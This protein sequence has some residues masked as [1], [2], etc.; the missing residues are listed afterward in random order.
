VRRYA[1]SGRVYPDERSRYYDQQNTYVEAPPPPPPSASYSY[2]GNPGVYSQQDESLANKAHRYGETVVHFGETVVN[3]TERAA[4]RIGGW[5]QKKFTG[6]DTISP[7]ATGETYEQGPVSPGPYSYPAHPVP[8][9]PYSQPVH[10]VPPPD[11]P[12]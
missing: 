11:D 12:D 9:D 3:K 8:P 1:D 5:F 4:R 6:Q 10:P 7:E 2:Y